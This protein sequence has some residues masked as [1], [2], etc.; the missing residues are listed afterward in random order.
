[1]QAV[2]EGVLGGGTQGG[3][4]RTAQLPRHVVRLAERVAGVGRG[5]RGNTLHM[6]QPRPVAAFMTLPSRAMP[7]PAPSWYEVSPI[8]AAPP[9]SSFGASLSIDSYELKRVVWRPRPSRTKPPISRGGLS[10]SPMPVRTRT[11]TAVRV[12]PAPTMAR[13]PSRGS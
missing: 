9:A 8:A 7:I 4:R 6:P 2:D 5:G 12:K 13:G 11:A 3:P 10:W 1:M